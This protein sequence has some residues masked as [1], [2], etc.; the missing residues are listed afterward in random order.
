MWQQHGIP[1]R[2]L[3][4][5]SW[6]IRSVGWDSVYVP[7]GQAGLLTLPVQWNSLRATKL[8]ARVIVCT[9]SVAL[10]KSVAAGIALM[11]N[12]YREAAVVTCSLI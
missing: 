12:I 10:R 5:S 11:D 7:P 1:K 8:M 2:A 3:A 4:E 6:T 9:N